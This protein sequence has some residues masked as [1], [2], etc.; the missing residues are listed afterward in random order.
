MNNVLVNALLAPEHE[1]E[2]GFTLVEILVVVIIIG[3]LAAVAIPIYLNQRKAAYDS[4]L[5]QDL[6]NTGM[7]VTT[8]FSDHTVE[9]YIASTGGKRDT[10]FEGEGFKYPNPDTLRWN[11]VFPDFQAEVSAGTLLHLQVHDKPYSH[12]TAH[13]PG[14]V[15]IAGQSMNGTYQYPGGNA[16]LYN[17]MLYYDS[18]AGG[19]LTIDELVEAQ[20][21]GVE[22]ACTGWVGTYRDAT[23][24]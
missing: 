15:C 5:A 13:T 23:G 18:N 12:W 19:V 1:R 16:K 22:I 2:D 8:Y 10:V 4:A 7:A 3:I 20:D 17:R 9:E 21:R 24:L 6:R 11:A 14:E